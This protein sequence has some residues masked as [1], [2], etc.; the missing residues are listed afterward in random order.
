LDK[1]YVLCSTLNFL[2]TWCTN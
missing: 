2:E 1:Y